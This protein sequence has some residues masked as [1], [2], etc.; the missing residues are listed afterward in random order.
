MLPTGRNLVTFDPRAIP[1]RSAMALAERAAATLLARHRQEQGDWPRALVIDLWGNATMRTGGEDFGLAL[2]LM[3]VRP[4]WDAGSSRVSGFEV[5]PL[6]VLDRPRVDVS[7]RISG[8]F[9]DA[10]G[11]QI[12]LFDQAARAVAARDEPADWNPLVTSFGARVFGPA[13]GVYGSG[14]ALD[15]DGEAAGRSYLAG[16]ATAWDGDA[17]QADAAGLAARVGAADGFVHT[18]DHAETDILESADYARP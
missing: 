9:R 8:L 17:G 11:T 10:F 14:V 18:Q 6:A 5:L 12:A 16:S 15:G 2:V 1:T 4:L 3:G 13:A 7:L